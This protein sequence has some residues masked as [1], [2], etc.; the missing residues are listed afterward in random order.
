MSKKYEIYTS[1]E[2]SGW[3]AGINRR[4]TARKTS[5]TKSQS[6]FASEAEAM[7]WAETELAALLKVQVERNQRHAKK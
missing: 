3:T 6:G 7:A 1:Q 5:V 2:D 4:V